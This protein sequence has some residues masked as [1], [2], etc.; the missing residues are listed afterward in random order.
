M[1]K[2]SVYCQK[3]A[4]AAPTITFIADDQG[5]IWEVTYAGMVRRHRQDW[6]AWCWYHMAQAAYAVCA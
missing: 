5:G 3:I 4:M 2:K 1:M 6:Q